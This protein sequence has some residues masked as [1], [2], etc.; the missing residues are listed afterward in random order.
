MNKIGISISIAIM[1]IGF[2]VCMI[3]ASS[4]DTRSEKPTKTTFV[5]DNKS[6]KEKKIYSVSAIKEIDGCLYVITELHT[7]VGTSV[8]VTPHT[9]CDCNKN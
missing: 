4:K 5:N 9:S 7:S 3:I 8:D 2:T 1:S 6:T